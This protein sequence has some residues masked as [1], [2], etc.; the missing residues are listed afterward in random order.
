MCTAII[1][2]TI[3]IYVQIQYL[4]T[5]MYSLEVQAKAI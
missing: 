3:V 4:T 2:T 5:L 1:L